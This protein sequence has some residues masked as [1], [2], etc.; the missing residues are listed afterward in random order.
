MLNNQERICC[1]TIWGLWWQLDTP[2]QDTIHT[3]VW[4][5]SPISV[6]VQNIYK[7]IMEKYYREII[8]TCINKQGGNNIVSYDSE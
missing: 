4:G 1:C 7:T 3:K 5:Y 6:G 2:D 8:V